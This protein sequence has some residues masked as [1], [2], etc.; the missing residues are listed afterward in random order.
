MIQFECAMPTRSILDLIIIVYLNLIR[1]MDVLTIIP[2]GLNPKLHGSSV[3]ACTEFS[4]PAR[5]L[6]AH[7]SIS[8]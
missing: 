5:V 7:I 2:L 8:L 6:D 3:S 4:E 1:M